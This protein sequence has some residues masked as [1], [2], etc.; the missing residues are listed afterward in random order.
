M[1][2]AL[3]PFALGAWVALLAA[4]TQLLHL[5]PLLA[6]LMGTIASLLRLHFAAT[7]NVHQT[8][9]SS[10]FSATEATAAQILTDLDYRVM[11]PPLGAGLQPFR[12][13]L[14]SG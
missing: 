7:L 4:L 13:R 8:V 9:F 12:W 10:Q 11:V 6:L 2:A 14:R 3:D 5:M 1:Q